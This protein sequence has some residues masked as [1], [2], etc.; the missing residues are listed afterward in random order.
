MNEH[1]SVKDLLSRWHQLRQQG[2][3]VSAEELCADSPELLPAIRERLQHLAAME[4]FLG[5]DPSDLATASRE[6]SDSRHRASPFQQIVAACEAFTRTAA[7]PSGSSLVAFLAQVP[8]DAQPLMLRNLLALE[9]ER[10]RGRGERPRPEEYL[11]RLPQ[12]ATVIREV[13]LEQAGV[14]PSL[15]SPHGWGRGGVGASAAV[16]QPRVSGPTPLA[17][18]LGGYRLLGELG[19]GG[20]GVVYEAVHL[21]RGHRVALKTLPTLD[22]AALHHFKRE[23]RALA[24]VHHP[25]LIGLHTLEADGSQWFF[26][27]DLVEGE[28]FLDHVCPHGALAEDR[29]RP[30]LAQL[31]R[32]VMALHGR[33]IIHRDLKPSNVLVTPDGRVVV[34]DFGLVL[35]LGSAEHSATGANCLVGTPRYMAPEQ[36]AGGRIVPAADWY[37][38]GVMLY[39][40]LAGRPPF[41]GS[42]M[43][44]LRDKQ[45]L[46]PPPL[47]EG[48]APADL[49]GLCLRL[50]ARD[51]Q[52]R[53][54]ALEIAR[55][56][57]P[58]S[59]FAE[60]AVPRSGHLLVGRDEH[61]AV[62]H[63]GY[64]TVERRGEPVTVL[65]S[66][67]SGEGKT[68]LAE[69]FLTGLR[70]EGRAVV[71]AGRCY[72]RESV[73]FKALDT[74]IDALAGYLRALPG[75][76]AALL[77]PDDLGAL[78][79]V[80]PVLQGVEVVARAAG[81]PPARP[82]EQHV[83]QRAFG[84]LRA[85]LGRLS[86]RAAVVW[87]ID[88]L[89]WGDADSAAALFEVLRPPEAPALL[90]VGSYRSDETERSAFL[91]VWQQQQH[92][93]SVRFTARE[94]NLGPLTVEECT[95]L[96]VR[97]L[98][99]DSDRVRR[100]ALEFAR[101]TQGNPF[102]LTELVGCY[103]PDSDSFEPLPLHEVLAR[104]LGRLPAEAARLLDVVAVSGQALSLEEAAQAA[105]HARPPMSA[106]FQ[107]RKERL[108][109]LIGPDQSPLVDTYHDRVRETV[110]GHMR[111]GSRQALHLR[112]G[113]VIEETAG[114]PPPN[115]PPPVGGG[116]GGGV[117]ALEGGARGEGAAQAVPRAH[118]LAYHFDAAGEKRKA[119]VYALLAAEQARRQFA[120]E[121]AAG[122]YAVA[123]RNAEEAPPAM[124]CRIRVGC[125][126][127]LM[128]LGRY[129]EAT[130]QLEA[131]AGLTDDPVPRAI[132]EGY[133][134]EIALKR[135][136]AGRSAALCESALRRLGKWV[137]RSRLGWAWALVREPLVHCLHRLFP[138][139]L[140]SEPPSA[141]NDLIGRLMTRRA[142]A[143]W[144]NSSPRAMCAIYAAMNHG[145]RFPPS[146]ALAYS[147]AGYGV[148]L[149]SFGRFVRAFHYL[150]RSLALRRELNDLWGMA[151]SLLAWGCALYSSARYEEAI[152]KLGEAVDLYR[153]T[154]DPHESNAAELHRALCHEKLGNVSVMLEIG[155]TIFA[156]DVRLGDDNS[157]HFTLFGWSLG[158][159]GDLPF[160]ELKALFRP[161]PDNV[162]AT[163]MLLMGEGHW[164]RHHSRTEEAL[165]AFK[166]AYEL[167]KRH[168]VINHLTVATLPWLV[169][170]LRRHADALGPRDGGRAARLRRRAFRLA[171]WATW[172]TRH[173]PPHHPH[174]LRELSHAY[175]A[176]GQLQEALRLAEQ[177]CAVAEGQR[178]KYE[179]AESLLLRG[180]LARRLG[181][182][183]AEE[184]IRTAEAALAARDE[185][186]RAATRRPL[187]GWSPQRQGPAAK[188]ERGA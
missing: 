94:V 170:A 24:D 149:V 43:Q 89:Q 139:R 84:A 185:A 109:R 171:R 16:P 91:R 95:D 150:D 74:L 27:M 180:R 62:L 86:R 154:G 182:P 124:R 34:L 58:G 127:A 99:E 6:A 179:H 87:F 163:S 178:A 57:A 46:D 169:T 75:E 85:L 2:Q 25:N 66:G 161:L 148:G 134:G 102:L 138:K 56:V 151:N 146:P 7:D 32:G 104:K 175:A 177:S 38:V 52:Q 88:D 81:K 42:L 39:Q 155:Q 50:L 166:S 28:P 69:H 97:L 20:M 159:R 30:A 41:E 158:A 82:D 174:A 133:L 173:F 186:I 23:F 13:F 176:R 5:V 108:V 164:H 117:A 137:P 22:G 100:R 44:V 106:L 33:H 37:A 181:L 128:L 188:A 153:K 125:G 1:A 14:P 141:P 4:R 36:A 29:L 68:T 21:H 168:V 3:D 121:V 71:M 67:R 72:D 132:I 96:V 49:A 55:V 152:A 160:E 118:D 120:L 19:R 64:R 65:V 92:R 119:S 143:Y 80:F 140:H 123:R 12:F 83:R 70:E 172:L 129:D 79:Q 47:P 105:G 9:I 54:D 145:E 63:E 167:V 90:F 135:G 115:P 107:M 156:H 26:T 8:P 45:R 131:A 51:P 184:Q 10:R 18:R 78:V 116:Q 111:A 98:G 73:P 48:A 162:L 157:G 122:Q 40:A 35:E 183:G 15:P 112:L 126:E 114:G 130:A 53:P 165:Q 31:V 61:L 77:M 11:E 93:D 60:R 142:Y 17:A 147:Y 113:E 144:M 101:E 59:T 110:L 76:E 103:D 136:W 187:P